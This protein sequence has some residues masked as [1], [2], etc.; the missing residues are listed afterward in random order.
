MASGTYN[1]LGSLAAA[2]GIGWATA[3]I[4]VLLVSS[5]YSYD[6]DH[7]TV[8]DV[9][10]SEIGVSGYARATLASPTV[11]VDAANNRVVLDAADV[12]FSALDTG[13]TIGGAV[14]FRRVAGADAGTDP[15]ITFVDLTDTPT[16]GG[17]IVVQW[18]AS[19]IARV[20]VG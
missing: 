6:A 2:G 3:T 11:T 14:V 20:T 15:L 13:A 10:G 5:A 19:G 17:D 16:N 9:S 8:A 4:R 18:S 12:T 1:S 7:A